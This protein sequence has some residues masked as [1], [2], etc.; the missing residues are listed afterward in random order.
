MSRVLLK[1]KKGKT[2]TSSPSPQPG[3]LEMVKV[4]V[5]TT[6]VLYLGMATD[7][8]APLM[9]VPD[10]DTLWVIDEFDPKLN[11]SDGTLENQRDEIKNILL[12]GS[13]ENSRGRLVHLDNSSYYESDDSNEEYSSDDVRNLTRIVKLKT[14]SKITNEIR[15]PDYWEL[16]FIYDNKPRTLIVWTRNFL[17]QWPEEIQSVDHVMVMGASDDCC[18]MQK[19]GELIR[20]FNER[21]NKKWSYYQLSYSFNNG[22]KFPVQFRFRGDRIAMITTTDEKVNSIK[23]KFKYTVGWSDEN[24]EYERG[25]I[26]TYPK[27]EFVLKK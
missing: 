20:M 5:K 24:V 13:N 6:K 18:I 22:P 9:W 12:A 25:L 8:I 17:I 26:K 1:T 15:Y 4:A 10:L 19:P 2:K 11:T 3:S 7:I 27:L 14:P 23:I 16:K 21:T